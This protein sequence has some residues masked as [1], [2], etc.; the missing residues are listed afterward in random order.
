MALVRLDSYRRSD[1]QAS[2]MFRSI[3]ICRHREMHVEGTEVP[4]SG[5]YASGGKAGSANA[6][7]RRV[8]RGVN[9]FEGNTVSYE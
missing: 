3:G 8:G 4:Y 9:P 1:H 2:H 7:T 6:K 5:R